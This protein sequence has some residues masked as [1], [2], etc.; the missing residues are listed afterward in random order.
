MEARR[1][2]GWRLEQSSSKEIRC[3]DYGGSSGDGENC[4]NSKQTVEEG[5]PVGV[6]EKEEP[7]TLL[8]FEPEQRGES[9]TTSPVLEL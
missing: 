8:G 2:A 6:K 3:L 1:P 5:L 9:G 4:T 7:R